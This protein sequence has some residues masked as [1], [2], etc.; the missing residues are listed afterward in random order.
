MLQDFIGVTLI[1]VF[2]GGPLIFFLL[3]KFDNINTDF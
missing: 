3:A 2:V 1:L